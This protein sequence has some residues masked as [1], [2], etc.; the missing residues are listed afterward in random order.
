MLAQ[1]HFIPRLEM[2]VFNVILPTPV[3]RPPKFG[4]A[5]KNVQNSARFLT[6]FDFDREYLRNYSRYPKS[7][8]NV[9]DS[10]SSRVPRKKSG[11]LW[12]TKAQ[13]KK[14]YWL[15]LSHPSGFLGE[16]IS[17]PRGCCALKFIHAL[18]IARALIA[19]TRSGTGVHP[20]KKLIVKI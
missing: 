10:D 4:R 6:T 15:E 9:I 18:E 2:Q 1:L 17:A 3:I 7:E 5:K 13:T 8:R 19:H 11:E 14:F 12:S 16:T 20:Q